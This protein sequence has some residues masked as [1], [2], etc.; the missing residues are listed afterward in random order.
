MTEAEWARQNRAEDLVRD[1]NYRRYPVGQEVGNYLRALRVARRSP[2][3]LASYETVLRLLTLEFRDYERLEDFS[4]PSSVDLLNGFLVRYWGDAAEATMEQRIAVLKSFFDWAFAVG[5][6]GR[7]PTLTIKAPRRRERIRRAR[8]LEEIRRIARAQVDS[9][10]PT[11][12]EAAFLLLGRL[13]LRKN[14]LR[15][16]RLRDIDLAHDL[17]YIRR[18]KGGKP[19]EV[20]IVFRDVRDALYLHLQERGGEPNEYL[21]YPKRERTRPMDRASVHRWF[22]RCLERAGADDFPMHELRHS[23]A[24]HLWRRTGNLVLAQQLLRHESIQTT[25]RYLH[26]TTEDLAAAMRKIDE[27]ESN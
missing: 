2:N 4:G 13:A 12:D 11:R 16:L 24:D 1:K 27:E 10:H 23:S 21:V 20:P 3:T 9:P 6:I 8:E 7:D 22:K 25:R 5:K 26:P 19:A 14:D 18:G 15:E 17:I